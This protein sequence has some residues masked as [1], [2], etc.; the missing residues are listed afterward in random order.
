VK[1]YLIVIVEVIG[2]ADR[3]M[4]IVELVKTRIIIAGRGLQVQ[5]MVIAENYRRVVFQPEVPM[6]LTKMKLARQV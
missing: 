5:M 2:W 4:P 3:Q 1:A 6:V